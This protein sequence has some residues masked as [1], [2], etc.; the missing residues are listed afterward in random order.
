MMERTRNIA[1]GITALVG[2]VG[3]GFMLLLFGSGMAAFEKGY[4]LTIH[5]NA[6]GG[7]SESSRVKLNGIDIG[8]VRMIRLLDPPT[9]G[10]EAKARIR[11]GVGIPRQVKLTAE[12][13]LFLGGSATLVLDVGGLNEEQAVD[14]LPS[15][16]TAVLTARVPASAGESLSAR[17]EGSLSEPLKQLRRLAD[18]LDKLSVEWTEVGHNVNKLVEPRDPQKVDAGEG[19]GNV[20][21]LVARADARL[22]ELASVLKGLDRWVSDQELQGHVRNVSANLDVMTQR[23]AASMDDLSVALA[24]LRQAAEQASKGQGSVGK[25]LNDPAL[26]NNLND[27]TVRLNDLLVE[28]KLLMEK[29]KAEGVPIQY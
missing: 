24:A 15:D 14:Y 27:A 17:F 5:L 18:N 21:S 2:M 22:G 4:D 25:M 9:R 3:L 28:A 11:E 13:P 19:L 7:L 1:V 16:G 8:D 6:A 23:F 10:I 12:T 29:W 26:Y 20:A